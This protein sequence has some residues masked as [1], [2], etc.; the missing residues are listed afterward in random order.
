MSLT[1]RPL[2]QGEYPVVESITRTAGWTH[3]ADRFSEQHAWEPGGFWLAEVDG[4][5]AASIAVTRYVVSAWIGYLV[6]KPEYRCQGIGRATME[7]AISH[8]RASGVQTIRLTATEAGARVYQKMGFEPEYRYLLYGGTAQG[9]PCPKVRL[10]TASDSDEI[11]ALDWLGFGDDR[12]RLVNDLI[13]TSPETTL[14]IPGS[15]GTPLGYCLYQGQQLGPMIS[16]PVV[17]E[18]LLDHA[19]HLRNGQQVTIEVPKAN[20][21]AVRLLTQRGFTVQ[22]SALRMVLGPDEPGEGQPPLVFAT[23]RRANG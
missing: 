12:L 15:D 2:H 3:T 18:A 19:L 8:L 22:G 7:H 5:P 17:A 13:A 20:G 21:E 16:S 14:V 23:M 4:V 10:A 9:R 11:A 1:I 6:V